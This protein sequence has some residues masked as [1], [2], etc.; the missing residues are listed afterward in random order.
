M[1]KLLR[2]PSRSHVKTGGR[3]QPA[4]DQAIPLVPSDPTEEK[5]SAVTI[6]KWVKLADIALGGEPARKKA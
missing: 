2:M 3:R 5:A 4:I 1:P 6:E